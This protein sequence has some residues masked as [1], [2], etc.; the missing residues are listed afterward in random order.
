VS[1]AQQARE[2]R[3]LS[4]LALTVLVVSFV[5]ARVFTT[6][7]P[8]TVLVSGSLH[9]H[10][11]WFGLILLAVGGLHAETGYEAWLR[12]APLDAAAAR[13]YREAV[14]ACITVAGESAILSNARQELIRGIRGMIGRT[15]RVEPRVPARARFCS[16]TED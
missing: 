7:S 15:L 6:I 13:Q 3:S 9:V 12:Y 14:P 10:H 5:I 11:F 8:D 1:P 4:V 16:T 2:R